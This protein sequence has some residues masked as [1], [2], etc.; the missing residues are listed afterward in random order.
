MTRILVTGGTGFL[1]KHVIPKLTSANNEVWAPNSK[2]LNVL[3]RDNLSDKLLKF[4]PDVILHM[5]ARCGGILANKNSPADFLRDN[6]Q[7]ALNIYEVAREANRSE[8]RRV[9]KECRS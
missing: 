6:T 5:A 7:M 8:E 9:G 1:G 4:R 2:Q 3:D